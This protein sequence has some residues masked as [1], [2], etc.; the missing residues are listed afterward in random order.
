MTRRAQRTTTRARAWALVTS[1]CLAVA[2]GVAGAAGPAS[3][4][5]PEPSGAAAPP[6]PA[7]APASGAAAEAGEPSRV[8]VLPA[9]VS[10]ELP[11][12]TATEV[13][14]LV[15]DNLV[16]DGIE[17]LL[18]DASSVECDEACRKAAAGAVGADFVVQVQVV[19]EEDEFTVTVTLYAGDTGQELVP[20]TDE[21][22]ICGFVEVRDMVRLTALDARAEVIRRRRASVQAPVVQA[23]VVQPAERTL[24]PRSRLVPAGWGLVGAGSAAT[25]GGVV[26][27]ALHHQ[28]AG[29]QENPRGGECVPLRYT[30]APVGGAVLGAGVA[31]IV[32]GVVMVVL[33]RRAERRQLANGV[34]VLPFGR[35]LRLRF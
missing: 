3:A 5:V 25:I 26:M 20:F 12:T 24:A 14:T 23:P 28:S 22:S 29:C 4:E 15:A 6:A 35:G 17:V 7:T 19:G 13:R 18:A 16:D 10:G 9:R 32:G 1:V 34:A 31:A 2:P 11:P 30:T 8:L 27:L 21:C 33:G